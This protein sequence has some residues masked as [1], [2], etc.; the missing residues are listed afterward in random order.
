[1]VII[2]LGA[3][4][5]IPSKWFYNIIPSFFICFLQ[6]NMTFFFSVLH[7]IKNLKAIRNTKKKKNW[8][9]EIRVKKS[10]LNSFICGPFFTC[11]FFSINFVSYRK[12]VNFDAKT[13]RNIRAGQYIDCIVGNFLAMS[14]NLT[15]PGRLI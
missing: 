8:W 13:L 5:K 2:V 12:Y 14:A 7:L 6:S 15:Q 9:F 11:F 10:S 3:I 4:I 1:M